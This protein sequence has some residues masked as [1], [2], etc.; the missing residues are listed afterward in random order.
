MR[1]DKALEAYKAMKSINGK[2]D[3]NKMKD[4]DMAFFESVWNTIE[5]NYKNSD[6]F[7]IEDYSA[8]ASLQPT[9]ASLKT[10]AGEN[11]DGKNE[12]INIPDVENS[13]IDKSKVKEK[14]D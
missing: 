14:V 4:E 8:L 9:V 5:K 2:F 1:E 3:E 6:T 13:I 12:S 11:W 7:I 10:L